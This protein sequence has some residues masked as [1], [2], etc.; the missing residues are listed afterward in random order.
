VLISLFG[1]TLLGAALLRRAFLP[2]TTGW[3]LVAW[4]PLFFGLTSVMAM[5]AAALPMIWAWGLAGRYLRRH[6]GASVLAVGTM[7]EALAQRRS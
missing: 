6:D 3:L 7:T 1:S 4:I 5:G 2:R